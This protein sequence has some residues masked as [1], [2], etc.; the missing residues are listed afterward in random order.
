MEV[1]LNFLDTI[2]RSGHPRRDRTGVGTHACFGLEMRFDL[3]R[4]PLVTTKRCHIRS[5]VYELLWMLKGD[6]NIQ[7]LNNFLKIVNFN[8]LIRNF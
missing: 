4:F 1:Y 6:T 3:Q 7:Y 5:I 2:M 8:I